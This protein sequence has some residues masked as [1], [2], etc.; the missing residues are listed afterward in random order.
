IHYQQ[1]VSPQ[2]D[3]AAT[4]VTKRRSLV[5]ENTP[6]APFWKSQTNFWTSAQCRDWTVLHYTY[7]EFD[8]LQM[9]DTAAVSK[10]ITRRARDLYYDD[11]TFSAFSG[12][13]PTV[14]AVPPAAPQVGFTTLTSATFIGRTVSGLWSVL[15][16]AGRSSRLPESIEWTV[17][18]RCKQSDLYKTGSI[19]IF[20]GGIPSDVNTCTSDERFAGSYD[21]FV[22]PYP[23]GCRNCVQNVDTV[24]EGF[25]HITADLIRQGLD[26]MDVG[27]VK[28]Y[29]QQNLKWAVWTHGGE[30]GRVED[31]KSLEVTVID[32]PIY[33]PEG[34]DI[35]VIGGV[36]KHN[37]VTFDKPGG[38]VRVP[39]YP[40]AT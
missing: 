10:A 33:G 24:L 30:Y 17:R 29:L 32:S 4:W 38:R 31:L 27:R 39:G 5:D 35:P 40:S 34:A 19:F 12:S 25:I 15:T 8:G 2:N 1:W 21:P 36:R 6:L 9:T 18:I 14:L 28:D 3:S 16:R 13:I 23:L 20:L 7:P 11:N 26:V 22:N 37:E